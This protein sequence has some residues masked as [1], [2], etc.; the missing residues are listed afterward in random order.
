MTNQIT[1]LGAGGHAKVV[2]DAARFT[3][4]TIRIL[5]D[6]TVRIGSCVGGI[7]ISGTTANALI[8]DLAIIAIGDNATRQRIAS[9]IQCSWTSVVHPTAVIAESAKLG[10]GTVVLAGCVVQADSRIGRHVILNTCSSVDH[11]CVIGDFVHICPGVH[12]PGNVTI[13]NGV[14][15][16]VSSTVLPGVR[17][18]DGA[19]VG[20]GAVVI[21]DV[22]PNVTVVG[23]PA[24]IIDSNRD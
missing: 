19:T 14:L 18:G 3:F 7:R 4:D 13:G 10:D 9:N 23:N 11:D 8:G 22:P 24:K 2:V 15:L 16:G 6:A 1:I 12:L 17:I 20:A 5:D 21:D